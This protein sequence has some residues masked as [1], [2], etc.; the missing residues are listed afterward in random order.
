MSP[1]SS[2][3]EYMCYTTSVFSISTYIFKNRWRVC[4]LGTFICGQWNKKL[5]V[6]L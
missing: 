3:M 5:C 4:L 2:T 1:A 6:S